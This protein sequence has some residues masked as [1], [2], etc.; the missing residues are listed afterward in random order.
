MPA[1]SSPRSGS[2]QPSDLLPEALRPQPGRIR[3]I[4]HR[5]DSTTA[6]ENT[7]EAFAAAVAAGSDLIEID[8]RCTADGEAAVIHDASALRTTGID[9]PVSALTSA[10]LGAADAGSWFGPEF[11]AARVPMFGA[12]AEWG[13]AHPDV[14]W[15]IEL[16]GSWTAA[17]LAGPVGAIRRHGLAGRTIL[18]GFEP[19]TVAAARDAAPDLPRALLVLRREDPDLLLERLRALGVAG[20][21]PI[22]N[23]PNQV[24]GLAARL[25]G[26]GYSV[27]PWTLDEP[28][29]WGAAGGAGVDGVITNRPGP[30][31]TWHGRRWSPA[32]AEALAS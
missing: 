3:T 32:A 2:T 20:C 11:A 19:E 16:K 10:E 13:T 12:V 18:Q 1:I 24:P 21:N 26:A 27:F 29:E 25:R 6:P 31:R 17:Q 5:G 7:L 22:G 23:L 28:D 15:L 4:A 30:F 9:A 8:L 14:G